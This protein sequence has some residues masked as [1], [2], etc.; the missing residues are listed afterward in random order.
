MNSLNG[1]KILMI[2]NSFTYYVKCVFE[3]TELFWSLNRDVMMRVIFINAANPAE[4]MFQLQTEL[5]ADTR[6]VIHLP[7][8]LHTLRSVPA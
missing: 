7:K 4:M 3:K 8:S 1:K 5:G 2:G 6:F